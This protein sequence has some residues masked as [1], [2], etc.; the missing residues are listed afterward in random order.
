MVM[1]RDDA[2][3][4]LYD[5]V[6]GSIFTVVFVK[7]NGELREMNCRKGVKKYL[8][9]AGAKYNP[10]EYDLVFVY[11]LKKQAYRTINISTLQT[12]RINGEEYTIED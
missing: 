10:R 1:K 5:L 9:G 8:T 4:F 11:D 12:L 2:R 7:K 6:G 3:K